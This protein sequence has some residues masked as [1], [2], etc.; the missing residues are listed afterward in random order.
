VAKAKVVK[1]KKRC[2]K[3]GPR[4]KR[5]PVVCKRLAKQGLAIRGN[6]GRYALDPGLRKKA[7]KAARA[8]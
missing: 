4:C 1:P 2:C 3:S 5:C 6:D 8:R 7:L